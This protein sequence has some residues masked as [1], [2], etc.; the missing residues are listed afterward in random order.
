MEG[1]GE[2]EIERERERESERSICVDRY[3][4]S[5]QIFRP[6]TFLNNLLVRTPGV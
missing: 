4:L 3:G 5:T 1:E 2:R 6:A